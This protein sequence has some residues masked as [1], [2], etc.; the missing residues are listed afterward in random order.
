MVKQKTTGSSDLKFSD[1]V[2][3]LK[4][5]ANWEVWKKC[6]EIALNGKDLSYWPLL[7][8]LDKRPENLPGMENANAETTDEEDA[9]DDPISTPGPTTSTAT[10]TATAQPTSTKAAITKRKK[11]QQEWDLKNAV[12]LAY[13]ASYLDVTM[14][15]YIRRRRSAA[16]V[17][18]ELRSLCE[19]RCTSF[20][21]G[22]PEGAPGTHR[23]FPP[24]GPN[25]PRFAQ[26]S[27]ARLQVIEGHHPVPAPSRQHQSLGTSTN[28]AHQAV[29]GNRPAS[30]SSSQH[31]AI[32]QSS[33]ASP[34][35]IQ[36]EIERPTD[37]AD[38]CQAG[39]DWL[40]ARKPQSR[41]IM[42]RA[43]ANVRDNKVIH[44]MLINTTEAVAES[45]S[46]S[47]ASSDQTLQDNIALTVGAVAT[48]G[49]NV[50]AIEISMQ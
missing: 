30:T 37:L 7:T 48:N 49:H 46:D 4:G 26:S 6:I 36:P 44:Q 34:Q 28:A 39:I 31:Q 3:S 41:E 50:K 2:P 40:I 27:V 12:V 15:V 33:A 10:T 42:R 1:L 32:A 16:Q 21:A 9:D 13:V 23:Q 20:G 11:A 45:V 47:T 35:D 22:S 17:Y 29:E 38:Q 43:M 24:A 14:L 25:Q 8:G 19:A 5:E 18:E